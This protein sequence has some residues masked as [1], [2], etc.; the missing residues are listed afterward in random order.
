MSK[1]AFNPMSIVVRDNLNGT[2]TLMEGLRYYATD[3]KVY[4]VPVGFLTDFGSIPEIFWNIPGLC[5]SGTQA[6]PAYV[7]HDWL[8]CQHRA[9]AMPTL[10]RHDADCLLLEALDVC[11]VGW[12]RRY[13]IYWGVRCGGWW[14]WAE[15]DKKPIRDIKELT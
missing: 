14:P 13:T 5:P 4:D 6:D 15:K 3:G 1:G 11:G 10:T 9:G 7:L 2:W 12:F 8:Y